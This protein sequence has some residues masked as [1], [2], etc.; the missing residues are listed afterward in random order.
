MATYNYILLESK[1][2]ATIYKSW[3]KRRAKP[4]THRRTVDGSADVTYGPSGWDEWYGLIRAPIT[5]PG[6]GWGTYAELVTML[7]LR[8]GLTFKTHDSAAVEAT[9]HVINEYSEDSAT[10]DLYGDNNFLMVDVRLIIE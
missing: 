2:Y 1:K 9:A 5:S 7:N 3:K 6:T 8:R 10:P 4:G